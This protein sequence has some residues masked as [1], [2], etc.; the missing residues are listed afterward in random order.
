[1]KFYNKKMDWGGL[2]GIVDVRNTMTSN[3]ISKLQTFKVTDVKQCEHTFKL[4]G[5]S[6]EWY[7]HPIITSLD[8]SNPPFV[9]EWHWFNMREI[10]EIN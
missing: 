1:M 9:V 7:G 4:V 8:N 2:S 10:E 6:E 5:F 3:E